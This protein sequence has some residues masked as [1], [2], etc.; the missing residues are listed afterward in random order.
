MSKRFFLFIFFLIASF[1]TSN[2]VFAYLPTDPGF[3]TEQWYLQKIKASQAW[4]FTKGSEDIV[5]AILDSGVDIDHPDLKDNIWVNAG[6]ISGDGIDNDNNGYIDDIHGWD[7]VGNDNNPQPDILGV[8]Y[9]EAGANH[10]TIIAGVLGARGDNAKGIAGITWYSKIM[11]LRVLNSV[12]L[13]DSGAAVQAIDYAI[14]QGADIINM[15]FV[16]PDYSS[17]MYQAVRRAWEK[18]IIIVAAAGN[19]SVEQGDDLDTYHSF[20]VCYDGAD[21]MVIGVAAVDDKDRKSVFSNF[22]NTY[23]DVA[24]PGVSFYSTLFQDFSSPDFQN[25]YGGY[26]SGTSV[27]TPLVSGAAALIK[28][29][30]PNFSNKKVRDI[31]IASADNIDPANPDIAGKLG[32]GRLNLYKALDLAYSQLFNIDLTKN[33]ITGAG[34]GGGP[35]VRVFQSSGIAITSFFA[36]DEGFRGGVTAVGCDLDGDGTS[37]IIAGAGIGGGP[38][39]RIFDRKG[40]LINLFFAYDERFRGG[41]NV[42]CG[43]LDGDGRDEIVTG[44]G[45]GGGPHVRIF[46]GDGQ[47][48]NHF[49]AYSE[50]FRG[51]VNVEVGDLDNNGR[52]EIFTGPASAGGPQVRIFDWHGAVVG[53]FFAYKKDFRGGIDIG[54][55]DLD[56]NGSQE[57]IVGVSRGGSSYIRVFDQSFILRYQF[58]A[59]L[60]EFQGGVNLA[61]ADLESDGRAEIITGAG[62]GGGPQVRIFNIEGKPLSQFF[63]YS[64]YFRGGV[65]VGTMKSNGE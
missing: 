35:H 61:V 41:V 23:V 40:K 31:I 45:I 43:D 37:E 42:A 19:D 14:V 22:G 65:N 26:W 13:G 8:P 49:F 50:N 34:I 15:S 44:A 36:Y 32:G 9:N 2:A 29:L 3:R 64:K 62:Q 60:D 25:E 46:N 1:F 10:G 18:G 27:A 21:N 4:D 24:A 51:G 47:L 17:A 12:G 20:P 56:D 5:I 52:A 39:V 7:F 28:S 33:I 59:Y 54:L 58:L 57:I 55:G 63:A 6:E 11:P 30:S 53:Q 48:V 38:H 16:G